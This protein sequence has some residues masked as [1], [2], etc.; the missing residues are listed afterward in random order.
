ME[1][2]GRRRKRLLLLDQQPRLSF[3]PSQH[4]H[5]QSRTA[6]DEATG[7]VYVEKTCRVLS[8]RD[9]P[10]TKRTIVVRARDTN[11]SLSRGGRSLQDMAFEQILYN[12]EDITAELFE[13]LPIFLVLR[14]WSKIKGRL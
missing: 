5:E 11:S 7:Q 13:D 14:I 3:L 10:W 8:S 9:Q 6:F 1:S 4:S 2:V 12:V